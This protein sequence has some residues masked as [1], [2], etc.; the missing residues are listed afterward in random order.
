MSRVFEREIDTHRVEIGENIHSLNKVRKVHHR[1]G[2]VD[3]EE[4]EASA[5]KN[6]SEHAKE[7]EAS[8]EK[9]N[10]SEAAGEEEEV[11]TA[12]LE[13]LESI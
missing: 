5:E 2:F 10:C 7:Q 1:I 6:S 3:A 8:A 13:W 12:L 9:N 4:K 11:P